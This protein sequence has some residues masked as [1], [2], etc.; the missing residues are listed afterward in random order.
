MLESEAA[1]LIEKNYRWNFTVNVLDGATFCFGM[2]FLSTAVVALAGWAVL[3]FGVKD[4][5]V[6]S[7]PS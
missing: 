5:K 6:T 2:S 1:P 4:P 7:N 3:R